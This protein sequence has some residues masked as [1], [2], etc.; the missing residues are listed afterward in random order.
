MARSYIALDTHCSSSDMAVV[1]VAGKLILTGLDY[2]ESHTK[3]TWT[4]KNNE[5]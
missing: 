1:N 4:V 2:R 3:L 5:E